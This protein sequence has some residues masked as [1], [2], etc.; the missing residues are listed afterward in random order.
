LKRFA[1][2]LLICLP[3]WAHHSGSAEYDGSKPIEIK[4]TVTEVDWANP[5]VWLHVEVKDKSGPST[6]WDFE[7][8]SPNLLL[9]N[10]W[11][12]NSLKPGDAVVVN[13][14][15]AKDA[16]HVAKA[17]SIRTADGRVLNAVT[18]VVPAR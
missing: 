5:H 4:G 16:E 3:T 8:G 9:I 11:R 12:K 6:E 14:M 2:L 13:A 17:K 7:L 10:G 1:G 15:P 18:P